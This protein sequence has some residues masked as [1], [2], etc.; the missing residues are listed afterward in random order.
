M[1]TGLKWAVA[2]MVI[3]SG[4]ANAAA[5]SISSVDMRD[6]ESLAQNH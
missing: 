6:G 4:T 2:I 1:K 3:M 5:F